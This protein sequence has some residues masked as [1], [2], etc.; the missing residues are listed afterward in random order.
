MHTLFL[1]IDLH[2]MVKIAKNR[3]VC[4]FVELFSHKIYSINSTKCHCWD[5]IR[6]FVELDELYRMAL[7]D[8]VKGKVVED[9]KFKTMWKNNCNI[10]K[11][12]HKIY[13]LNST[14]CHCWDA[15]RGYVELVELYRLALSDFAKEQL[16]EQVKLKNIQNKLRNV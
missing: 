6:G 3:K 5:A 14:K 7:S 9:I 1:S 11:Q 13:S 16:A 15:I 2:F 4:K 12:T 10:Y 8:F